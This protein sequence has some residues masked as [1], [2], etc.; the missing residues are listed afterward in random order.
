MQ[1]LCGVQRAAG[2]LG[3]LNSHLSSASTHYYNISHLPT[4]S[5][6][7]RVS[8]PYPH[9]AVTGTAFLSSSGGGHV[10]L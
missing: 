7:L 3:K 6:F 1:T 8:V 9:W 2:E 5:I 10:S 4:M